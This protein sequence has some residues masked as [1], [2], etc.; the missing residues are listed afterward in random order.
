MGDG[1]KED[2]NN[3]EDHVVVQFQPRKRAPGKPENL[4]PVDPATRASEI[5]D[6]DDPVLLRRQVEQL[7]SVNQELQERLIESEAR[8][9]VSSAE[10]Q[11]LDEARINAAKEAIFDRIVDATERK[12]SI[13]DALY[14]LVTE[15]E[16]QFLTESREIN[17]AQIHARIILTPVPND[18]NTATVPNPIAVLFVKA[19]QNIDH[20]TPIEQEQLKQLRKFLLFSS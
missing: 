10:R 8:E 4:L 17:E 15:L 13:L 11:Q 6:G 3:R 19:M 20:A 18:D 5:I 9:K 14:H 16:K 7:S 2:G 1:N 12:Q